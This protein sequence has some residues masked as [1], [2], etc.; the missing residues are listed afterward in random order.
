MNKICIQFISTLVYSRNPNIL[1]QLYYSHVLFAQ[2]G[3]GGIEKI[4]ALQ[5]CLFWNL[6]TLVFVRHQHHLLKLS[7]VHRSLY[8]TTCQNN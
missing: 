4:P 5:L 2:K 1:L 3:S 7:Y 8:F 6:K